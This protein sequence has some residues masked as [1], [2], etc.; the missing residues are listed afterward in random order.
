M[1]DFLPAHEH[2]EL[3]WKV[4]FTIKIMCGASGTVE[5]EFSVAS[6]GIDD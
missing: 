3:V 5:T 4:M 6:V 2:A 1:T